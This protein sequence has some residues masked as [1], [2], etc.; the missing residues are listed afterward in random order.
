MPPM[1]PSILVQY[2][3]R[4]DDANN[5]NNSSTTSKPDQPK[6]APNAAL[7]AGVTT[8]IILI[9]FFV[10]VV[11][12][13][14]LKRRSQ[15]KQDPGLPPATISRFL[16][17]NSRF[18]RSFHGHR[19]APS[20]LN[21]VDPGQAYLPDNRRPPVDEQLPFRG[22]RDREIPAV[23]FKDEPEEIRQV[24][25]ERPVSHQYYIP[26]PN[27]YVEHPFPPTP[28]TG[29]N[30]GRTTGRKD[31]NDPFADQPP[32]SQLH[33]Y[34]EIGLDSASPVDPKSRGP[35]SA[36]TPRTNGLTPKSASGNQD[37]N[38]ASPLTAYINHLNALGDPPA[39][40]PALSTFNVP[41]APRS[42]GLPYQRQQPPPQHRFTA[43]PDQFRSRQSFENGLSSGSDYSESPGSR[44]SSGVQ[45]SVPGY[46]PGT[47]GLGYDQNVVPHS[48]PTKGHVSFA[49]EQA[50]ARATTSRSGAGTALRDRFGGNS[51]RPSPGVGPRSAGVPPSSAHLSANPVKSHFSPMTPDYRRSQMP[52]EALPEVPNSSIAYGFALPP[53]PLSPGD[54]IVVSPSPYHANFAMNR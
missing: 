52:L 22:Q 20:K 51:P 54:E 2:F 23:H 18:D 8:T 14:M 50:R 39:T 28:G 44:S 21:L 37:D 11:V 1:P 41:A 7:I 9:L 15:E 16:D 10:L 3:P 26:P 30:T 24:G 43:Q 17:K 12:V 33:P 53:S 45:P 13:P 6:D 38:S 40:A 36:R 31:D 32:S 35:Q 4:D 46:G 42:A 5:S 47:R 19:R 27:A 25:A 49:H 34:H 29:R 48:M